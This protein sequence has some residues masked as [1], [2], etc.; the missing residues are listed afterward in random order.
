MIRHM[1][2]F[3]LRR[4]CGAAA[5]ADFFAAAQALARIEGVR[6]LACFRQI[7]PK[8]R[9]QH[10]ITMKFDDADAYRRYCEHPEH[11][12]FVEER[13]KVAVDE[14]MEIDLALRS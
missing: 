11:V 7:S 6:E 10:G 5:E 4:D 2:V 1:V 8:C 14:F 12:S 3:R 13:W 9:F